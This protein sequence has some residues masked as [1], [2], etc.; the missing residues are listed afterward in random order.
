MYIVTLC[1]TATSQYNKHM[2]YYVLLLSKNVS[3]HE[4]VMTIT[5]E[6]GKK[7]GSKLWF[8]PLKYDF[9]TW[10]CSSNFSQADRGEISHKL[11]TT[12]NHERSIAIDHLSGGTALPSTLVTCTQSVAHHDRT[13]IICMKYVW[14][15]NF[16]IQSLLRYRMIFFWSTLEKLGCI[17]LYTNFEK[18]VAHGNSPR[19]QQYTLHP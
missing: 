3:K 13:W 5:M 17:P 11:G 6:K 4:E 10:W 15:N 2:C 1:N 7:H 14:K 19:I 12:I 18:R 8:I 16:S 9:I